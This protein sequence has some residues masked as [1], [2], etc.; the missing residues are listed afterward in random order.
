MRGR[1]R[2][3]P[4][5]LRCGLVAFALAAV[6]CQL[7]NDVVG[8]T[9]AQNAD[10]SP[11]DASA[12]NTSTGVSPDDTAEAPPVPC[13]GICECTEDPCRQQCEIGGVCQWTCPDDTTCEL[14][15]VGSGCIYDCNAGSSCDL[16]C[17]STC[18]ADC[19]GAEICDIDCAGPNCIVGCVD[20]DVCELDCPQGNCTLQCDNATTCRMTSCELG[21]IVDC[22]DVDNCEN[23]C[24]DLLAGCI[25]SQM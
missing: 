8:V 20:T 19:N 24:D 4:A 23:S 11:G 10:D 2:G 15:C 7:P 22:T 21:C 18:S 16:D 12:A 9:G 14:D 3:V 5:H 1:E 17:E 13:P 6:A 25:T